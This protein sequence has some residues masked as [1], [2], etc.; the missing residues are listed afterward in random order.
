MGNAQI[1]D[2]WSGFRPYSE[3][4]LPLLGPGPYENL[5]MATGHFRN[6]ILL[7][8]M[9][10]KIVAESVLGKQSSMDLKPFL[11]SRLQ[12]RPTEPYAV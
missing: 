11:F 1:T 2:I 9:T 4:Y 5:F 10:A 3:G 6:G 12:E 7:A 8:A